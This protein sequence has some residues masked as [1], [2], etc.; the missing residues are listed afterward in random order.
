MIN[1]K[2]QIAFSQARIA[3]VKSAMREST[4]DTNFFFVVGEQMVCLDQDIAAYIA[5]QLISYLETDIRIC[6]GMI[7][8]GD[9]NHSG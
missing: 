2:Q 1:Y 7:N 3:Q 4:S 5:S 9:F 6:K 8:S